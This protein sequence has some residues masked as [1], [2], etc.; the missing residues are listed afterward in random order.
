MYLD[1]KANQNNYSY[2]LFILDIFQQCLLYAD[3]TFHEATVQDIPKKG[4][5]KVDLS[6]IYS[7]QAA[8]CNKLYYYDRS[9]P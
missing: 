5:W 3:G 8:V 9:Y 4:S 7:L 1:S 6:N 2:I